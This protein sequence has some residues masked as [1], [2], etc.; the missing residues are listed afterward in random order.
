MAQEDRCTL[1]S[2]ITNSLSRLFT[3]SPVSQ[4]GVRCRI[5]NV[6][7]DACTDSEVCGA[8]L[9]GTVRLTLSSTL[10]ACC[11][12]LLQLGLGV[13]DCGVLPEDEVCGSSLINM[14]FSLHMSVKLTLLHVSIGH[15]L[16]QTDVGH[17]YF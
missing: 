3:M 8:I 1:G 6:L 5:L 11:L 17:F 7:G 4:S 14:R 9:Q 16:A 15:L 13:V 2:D 12:Q 10:L